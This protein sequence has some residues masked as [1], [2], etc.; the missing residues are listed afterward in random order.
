MRRS[1]QL[2]LIMILVTGTADVAADSPT[3]RP[4]RFS[5]SGPADRSCAFRKTSRSYLPARA[6]ESTAD[7]SRRNP[8]CCGITRERCT[9]SRRP[10]A[11]TVST[12]SWAHHSTAL[13]G[14]TKQPVVGLSSSERA[15]VSSSPIWERDEAE[16]H[17]CSR[18]MGGSLRSAPGV[19]N[20]SCG[21]FERANSSVRHTHA[22]PM[23]DSVPMDGTSSRRM[24]TAPASSKP[25]LGT[26]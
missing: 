21:T 17:R 12:P 14:N 25:R 22:R 26:S 11:V 20:T 24:R 3:P 13:R 4:Y 10:P 9:R 2:F 5:P 16:R 6:A 1:S 18:P 7:P 19:A 8:L 15:P 23:S